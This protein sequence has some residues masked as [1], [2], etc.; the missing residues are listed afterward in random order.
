MGWLSSNRFFVLGNGYEIGEV[1][2]RDDFVCFL[3]GL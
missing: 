1:V 2:V 3:K